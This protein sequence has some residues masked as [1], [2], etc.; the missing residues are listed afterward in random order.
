MTSVYT[1][2]VHVSVMHVIDRVHE[3]EL[4]TLLN[5]CTNLYEE[6]LTMSFT[7]ADCEYILPSWS[8]FRLRFRVVRTPEL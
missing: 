4:G 2:L 8:Q 3:M 7:V 5:D 1:G 6:V